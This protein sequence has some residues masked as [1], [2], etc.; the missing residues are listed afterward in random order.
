MR[1][2]KLPSRKK[3]ALNKWRGGVLHRMG[4]GTRKGKEHGQSMRPGSITELNRAPA[5]SMNTGRE[6]IRG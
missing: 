6:W 5:E 3:G 1:S 4:R 2:R